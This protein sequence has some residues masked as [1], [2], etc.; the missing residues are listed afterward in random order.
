MNKSDPDNT[1]SSS[2]KPYE[3]HPP[4]A[5]RK[6]VLSVHIIE[7]E[8]LPGY[9]TVQFFNHYEDN[10][11]PAGILSMTKEEYFSPIWSRIRSICT[12]DYSDIPTKAAQG[13][14]PKGAT[15]KG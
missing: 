11:I 13:S 5:D 9:V 8:I 14:Q 6:G 2:Y 7:Q 4:I 12:I 10:K 3:H 1:S 15:Q